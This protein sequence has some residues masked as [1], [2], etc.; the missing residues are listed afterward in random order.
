MI[1]LLNLTIPIRQNNPRLHRL[2]LASKVSRSSPYFLHV[3]RFQ[4]FSEILKMN[5]KQLNKNEVTGRFAAVTIYAIAMGYLESAVVI[6]LRQTAFGNSIQVFPIRFLD[7]QLGGIE[8]TR[9]AATIIMLLAVG[10]LAGRNRFQQFMFFVFSFAVW[11]IFYYLFLKISTGWPAT[12]G[13][14]DVL[15]LIPVI[16]IGPVFSPIL[17]SLLLAVGAT[18]LIFLSEKINLGNGKTEGVR[19]GLTNIVLFLLGSAIDFY[20]FTEQIFRILINQGTKGLENFVPT[21]FDL[22][23]FLTGYVLLCI[24]ATRIV[25]GCYNKMTSAD[26]QEQIRN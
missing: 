1:L 15:F 21:S 12:L 11:D 13:D 17:I 25:I 23:L 14:F 3:E 18:F 6:Y 9:E 7:P 26:M 5:Y 10:Y 19:I 8:F 24:S 4:I 2:R 22:P 20:S 16:W